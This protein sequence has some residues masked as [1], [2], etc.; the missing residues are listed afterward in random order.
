[1]FSVA[2]AS[3]ELERRIAFFSRVNP[4]KHAGITSR[5]TKGLLRIVL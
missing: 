2:D 5:K 1:V 4:D 3:E